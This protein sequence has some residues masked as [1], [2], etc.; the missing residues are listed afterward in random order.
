MSFQ[1]ERGIKEEVSGRQHCHTTPTNTLT[2]TPLIAV[3]TETLIRLIS[4]ELDNKAL[5]SLDICTVNYAQ[6]I[7]FG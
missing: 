6:V 2:P 3:H 5:L 1:Q 7:P 4:Q